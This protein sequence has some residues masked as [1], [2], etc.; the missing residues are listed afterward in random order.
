[1]TPEYV[2]KIRIKQLIYN[3]L[4]THKSAQLT[5]RTDYSLPH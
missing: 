3:Y 1:M 4:S 5:I 2:D